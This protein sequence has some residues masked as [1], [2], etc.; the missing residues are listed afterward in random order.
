ML[1]GDGSGAVG[2]GSGGH[3]LQG[4]VQPVGGNGQ[5][6]PL[7]EIPAPQVDAVF[8]NVHHIALRGCI[9]IYC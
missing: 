4:R 3:G 6:F 5:E 9:H 1:W 8:V 2:I 7:Y